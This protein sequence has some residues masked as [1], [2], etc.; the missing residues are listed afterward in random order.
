[1]KSNRGWDN[2]TDK[3]HWTKERK[4]KIDN[5]RS[6]ERQDLQD[7]ALRTNLKARTWCSE[8]Y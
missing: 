6:P 4:K 2:I 5:C 3:I 1:M 7:L 8:L